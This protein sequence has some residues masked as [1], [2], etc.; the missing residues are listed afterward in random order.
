MQG[1]YLLGSEQL[2]KVKDTALYYPCSGNDLRTPIEIFSPYVTDFWFVDRGYFSTGHQDTQRYGF[3]LPADQQPA[4]LAGDERYQFL[5]R[6][7]RGP[8]DWPSRNP[9][10]KPCV[11]TE[12]Y[13]HVATGRE[14]RI[15]RRRGYGYS[16]F[17][18]EIV[19]G[20]LGVFL[21]RGD[22]Q[23]E[24][25]SGNTWLNPEHIDEVCQKLVDGGLMALDGSD[26]CRWVRR[27]ETGGVYREFFGR[28]QEVSDIAEE[29][30]RSRHSFADKAGRWFDCVGYA[31]RRY[32]PTMIWQVWGE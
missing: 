21:S 27:Y 8:S 26:G 30:I 20:T 5:G 29:L 1:G 25:G 16:G 6:D 22:S 11:L 18:K 9:K 28:A 19:P 32:G 7:I 15:H 4:V 3:D 10:I 14:I 23:G 24:G 31:G 17:R 12:A 13:R 2:E